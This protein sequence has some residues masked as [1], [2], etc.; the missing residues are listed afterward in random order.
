MPDA[1]ADV[2]KQMAV[3][4]ILDPS[5]SRLI[6]HVAP[7]PPDIVWRNTYQSRTTR[8][9]RAWSVT[10]FVGVLSIFWSALLVPVSVL[11]DIEQIRKVLPGFG[12][13]LDEHLLLKSLVQ[14]GLPTLVLSLLAVAVPYIYDCGCSQKQH[15][16]ISIN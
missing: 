7:A 14:T 9:A 13:L 1:L 8:M 10:V 11:L 3:Q 2:T 6:A 4:A 15:L 5:P 16:P 12:A